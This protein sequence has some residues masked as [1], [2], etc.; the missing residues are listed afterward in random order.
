MQTFYD[1]ALLGSSSFG[2]QKYVVNGTVKTSLLLYNS[3]IGHVHVHA[4]YFKKIFHVS[5]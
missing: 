1:F 5:P 2:H 4:T 3:E